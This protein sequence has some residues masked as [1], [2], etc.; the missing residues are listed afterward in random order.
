MQRPLSV[1]QSLHSPHCLYIVLL[2][3]DLTSFSASE[4]ARSLSLCGLCGKL[5]LS[6]TCFR[7]GKIPPPHELFPCSKILSFFLMLSLLV[8][9]RS[10]IASLKVL[11]YDLE[12][13]LK[14]AYDCV[15]FIQTIPMVWAGFAQSR[16]P[17]SIT[18]QT[19]QNSFLSSQRYFYTN[20]SISCLKYGCRK[21]NVIL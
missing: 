7:F 18:V 20:S 19:H 1:S 11:N 2:Q 10:C 8:I 16:C 13:H 17:W 4:V 9:L 15:R 12:G 21:D 6:I 3:V 14:K 5:G